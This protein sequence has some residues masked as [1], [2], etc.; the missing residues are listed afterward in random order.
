MNDALVYLI[1]PKINKQNKLFPQSDLWTQNEM[2]SLEQKSGRLD[3][4]SF[5]LNHQSSF[6]MILIP[7]CFLLAEKIE[8][9]STTT[10]KTFNRNFILRDSSTNGTKERNSTPK[11]LIV[12]HLCLNASYFHY[13]WHLHSAAI[14]S[15]DAQSEL[16]AWSHGLLVKWQGSLYC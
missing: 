2:P 13:W 5:F 8:A 15:V 3:S 12:S 14:L 9:S 4:C 7:M 6:Q 11:D 16:P 10:I 1:Y